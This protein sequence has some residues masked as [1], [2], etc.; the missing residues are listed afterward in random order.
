MK[1]LAF[2]VSDLGAVVTGSDLR[3]SAPIDQLRARGIHVEIAHAAHNVVDG[4]EVVYSS[5]VP[6]D[7]VERRRAA[8]LGLR[9]TRRGDLLAELTT[10]KRCIAVAGT[11]GKTTT[12]A[13]IVHALTACGV[14]P[15]HVIGADLRDGT[16]SAAWRAGDWLVVETDESD[17]TFLAVRPDIAV[18][19]NVELDHIEE[20]SSPHEV[21]DAFAA[22]AA[23][24]GTVV[25]PGAP[26][27][28]PGAGGPYGP[29]LEDVRLGRSGSQFR[30]RGREV[31]LA[32]PGMHNILNAVCALEACVA[33][34]TDAGAAA[35]AL[36]DFPGVRRRIE[37]LGTADSG[38][39]VYTDYLCHATALRASVAAVRTVEPGRIVA[40]FEPFRFTRTQVMAAALGE[41]LAEADA[42]VVLELYPG[43]DAYVQH[44][45]VS[46]SLVAAAARRYA[47]GRPVV[48]AEATGKAR[49]YLM[50]QLGPGDACVVM[51][52]GPKSEA[53]AYSLV[54]GP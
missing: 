37:L 19:T 36:A 23:G 38:A 17:R 5:A 22:F 9:Q 1:A 40:V 4:V 18:V 3:H 44:P 20:Y 27:P 53:L 39:R 52:V 35:R 7:N 2:A 26:H 10:L 42:A 30:W 31:G 51:G 32:V 33:A 34:G 41:A 6:E 11:H 25:T 21:A 46:G 8:Q 29:W 43:S 50:A 24:A 49:D 14:A 54:G 12:A 13:M 28:E 48:W 47:A 15:S 16:P 45:H